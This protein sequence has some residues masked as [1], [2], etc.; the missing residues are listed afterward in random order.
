MKTCENDILKM[1]DNTDVINFHDRE[2]VLYG[3][4]WL[5]N[6]IEQYRD[7]E[8]VYVSELEN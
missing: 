2:I 8:F 1:I 6:K 5:I 3:T 4:E 7:N